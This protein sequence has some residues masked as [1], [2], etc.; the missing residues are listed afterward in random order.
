MKSISKKVFLGVEP[1]P[2]LKS[3]E[4]TF[5]LFRLSPKQRQFIFYQGSSKAKDLDTNLEKYR[6]NSRT[7]GSWV[8]SG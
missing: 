5:L 3:H 6:P 2:S 7:E 8:V 1:T 4:Y